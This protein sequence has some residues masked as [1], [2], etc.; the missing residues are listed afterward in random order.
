MRSPLKSS[1]VSDQEFPA[2]DLGIGAVAGSV[3][4]YAYYLAAQMVLRHATGDVRVMM[5]HAD[6]VLQ[7]QFQSETR[8]HVLSMQIV[9]Y[10]SR[11]NPK[12]LLQVRQRFLEEHQSLVILQI[13]N[14]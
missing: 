2:P 8:A 9:G 14:V 4:C 11:F 1:E 13:A 12:K 10:R 6:F 5:L 7:R 3:E